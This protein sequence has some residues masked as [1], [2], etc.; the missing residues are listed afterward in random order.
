LE[1][2]T[3]GNREEQAAKCRQGRKQADGDV[4]CAKSGQKDRE[5]G[6]PRAGKANANAIDQDAANILGLSVRI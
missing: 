2:T 5:I 3:D 6:L 1:E 4:R